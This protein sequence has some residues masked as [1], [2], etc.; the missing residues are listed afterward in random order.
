LPLIGAAPAS[1]GKLIEAVYAEAK[2]RGCS[3]VYWLTH[4]TN[5]DAMLL[6]DRIGARSGFVQYRK[7]F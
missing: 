2:L 6:Y 3:R 5:K 7:I 4:E 1:G